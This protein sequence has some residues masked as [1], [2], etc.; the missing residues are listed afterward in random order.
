[1]LLRYFLQIRSLLWNDRL[2]H[3]AD[4]HTDAAVYAGSKVNPI[5][6]ITLDIFAWAFVNASHW[7]GIYAI[8]NAFANISNNRVRHSVLSSDFLASLL[9]RFSLA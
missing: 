6:V 7:T 3:W 8:C 5:P 4:L 9:R 2:L 1:M